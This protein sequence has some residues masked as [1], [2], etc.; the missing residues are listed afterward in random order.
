MNRLSV[1]TLSPLHVR[2][3]QGSE[4]AGAEIPRSY[5]VA[6]IKL[7][8]SLFSSRVQIYT[9]ILNITDTN[10]Q[11]IL[12][13]PMPGRWVKAGV[14]F[15]LQELE[16]SLYLQG[17]MA[18]PLQHSNTIHLPPGCSRTLPRGTIVHCRSRA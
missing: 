1:N 12:G 11:E 13:A 5:F 15:N 8:Y 18:L 2:S 17:C 10:Y 4:L 6:N 9:D 7:G 3:P 16:F 14:R